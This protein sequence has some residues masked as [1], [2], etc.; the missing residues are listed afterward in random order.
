MNLPRLSLSLSCGGLFFFRDLRLTWLNHQVFVHVR[1][2]GLLLHPLHSG[3][4]IGVIQL[5]RLLAASWS[6]I[7]SS[8]ALLVSWV[9]S[10]HSSSSDP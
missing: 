4:L 6:F 8:A 7:L 9:A 3:P 1:V 5:V 2:V 10:G